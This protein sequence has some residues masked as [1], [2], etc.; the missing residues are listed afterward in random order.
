VN[1]WASRDPFRPLFWRPTLGCRPE[2]PARI[3][4]GARAAWTDV[5]VVRVSSNEC[6]S[7]MRMMRSQVDVSRHRGLGAR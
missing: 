6:E 1:A 3:L 7:I 2:Q 5:A 4:R